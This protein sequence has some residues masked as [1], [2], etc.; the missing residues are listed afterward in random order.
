MDCSSRRS[1]NALS[2]LRQACGGG[3]GCGGGGDSRIK[4]SLG[5]ESASIV[6]GEGSLCGDLGGDLGDGILLGFGT[7]GGLGPGPEES[8]GVGGSP[9]EHA[10]EQYIAP[11]LGKKG[12]PNR[13]ALHVWQAKH[14]SVACQC[15]PSWD[16][17]PWSTPMGSPHASQYS[18]KQ[19]S[20]QGRQ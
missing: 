16:I 14:R 3:G 11:F 17:W 18:A 20:K 4:D 9:L 7:R 19:L 10:I 13:L 5:S 6:L 1:A 15:W 12:L 8:D 2:R